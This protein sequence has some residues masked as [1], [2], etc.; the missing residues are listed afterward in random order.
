MLSRPSKF[1]VAYGFGALF[2][3]GCATFQPP[4]PTDQPP[5]MVAARPVAPGRAPVALVLSGGSA[6]GFAHVGVIKVLH[7][8]GLKPDIIGR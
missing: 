7:A 3:S 5:A 1:T 4:M 6:R 2:M 8:N